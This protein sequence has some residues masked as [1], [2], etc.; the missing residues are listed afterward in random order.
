M[1]TFRHKLNSDSSFERHKDRLVGDG[2]TQQ[3]GIDCGDP[4]SPV[5]KP[6]IIRIVV[7]LSLSQSWSIN[8]L[9]VKNAFLHADLHETIYMYQPLGFWYHRFANY[10]STIGFTHI[11]S[12]HSLFIYKQ[13]DIAYVLLYIDDIILIAFSSLFAGLLCHF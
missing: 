13:G 11:R 2:K 9:D 12:G 3:V 4:F 5:I 6:E 7:I 10:V 8:Q 1:W